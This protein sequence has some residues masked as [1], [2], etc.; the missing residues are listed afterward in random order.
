MNR[1]TTL[2]L[3]GMTLL[4]VTTAALPQ[5]LGTAPDQL[6]KDSGAVRNALLA[7]AMKPQVSAT[8]DSRLQGRFK[9]P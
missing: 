6:A 5:P 7:V 3:T 2:M 1:L 4:G 8:P 9:K